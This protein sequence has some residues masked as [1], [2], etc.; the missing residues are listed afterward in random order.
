MTTVHANT[1]ED[2]PE[3]ITDMCMLDGRAM[4]PERLMK[5]IT[6][7][8]TQVG[9]EM[10]LISGRRRIVRIGSLYWHKGSRQ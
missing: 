5:R 9:I 1:L 7:Y 4:N 2:L 3:A 8:V 6:E 10:R